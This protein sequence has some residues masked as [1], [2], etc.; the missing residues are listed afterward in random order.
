M[1][2]DISDEQAAFQAAVAEYLADHCTNTQRLASFEGDGAVRR[3][4]WDGLCDLGLP[5]IAVP[6]EHGGLGL[7][8]LD[9]ALVAEILG[10]FAC[11]SPFVEHSLATLAIAT[12]G[13]E[14]Q[15]RR[16]LPD[17]ATGRITATLAMA[18]PGSKWLPEEW[19]LAGG[20]AIS[21]RKIAVPNLDLAQLIVVSTSGGGLAVVEREVAR[22][23]SET[24]EPSL[25][26]TRPIS[27]LEFVSTPAEPLPHAGEAF[28]ERLRDAALIL[29]AADALGGAERCV[30]ATC[31]YLKER[32]QFGVPIASFQAVKHQL[33][34]LAVLVAPARGLYWYAAHV[35]DHDPQA[36]PLAAAMAKAHL[37][38]IYTQVTR[39]M[40]EL[41]GGIGYTW[42]FGAHVWLRRA[43]YDRFVSGEPKLHYRRI[44]EM[45]GW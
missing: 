23:L 42:E 22:G 30:E 27:T 35:F 31:D 34:N 45:S 20:S 7:G 4:L 38:E 36:A 14:A 15:R 2:F 3:V 19:T 5:A 1:K 44:A 25:D 21:G 10:R 37:S 6:Q 24:P 11:P 18:E 16:W 17:L 9:V 28:A 41:H 39:A 40:I 29:L 12:A 8:W 43:V 32:E 33:A 26:A 13:D